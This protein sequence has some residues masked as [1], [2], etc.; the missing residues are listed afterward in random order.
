M[1]TRKKLKKISYFFSIFETL[2]NILEYL[3]FFAA[4]EPLFIISK[5]GCLSTPGQGYFKNFR[6]S[7]MGQIF[8]FLLLGFYVKAWD[9]FFI[10]GLII[11]QDRLGA[12]LADG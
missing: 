9:F 10:V 11:A 12:K 3:T 7:G 4:F 6:R 1:G 5:I 8:R 2:V